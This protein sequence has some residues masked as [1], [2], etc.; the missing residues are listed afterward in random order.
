MALRE[1]ESGIE[2]RIFNMDVD[3]SKERSRERRKANGVKYILYSRSK[4]I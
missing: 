4:L 2:R 3:Y 1:P